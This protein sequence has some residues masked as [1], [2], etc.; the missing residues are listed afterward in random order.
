MPNVIGLSNSAASDA[1]VASGWLYEY[2]DYTSVGATAG[3]NGTVQSQDPAAGTTA[4]CGLNAGITLYDYTP[5]VTTSTTTATTTTTVALTYCPSLGYNVPSSGY[6]DNCPGASTTTTTVATTATTTSTA[7]TT[8]ASTTSS[9]TSTTAS[10]DGIY[11]VFQGE[12]GYITFCDGY[13]SIYNNCN[14]FLGC[15][16]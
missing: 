11:F 14:Q 16:D 9:T 3:N 7:A 12:P 5:P 10:C 8:T 6:P 2:T 4:Q 15:N 13:A 1:I